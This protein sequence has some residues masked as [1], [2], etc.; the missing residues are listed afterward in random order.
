VADQFSELLFCPTLEALRNLEREGMGDRAVLSG[1]IMF[2]AALH[3]KQGA[4]ARGGQLAECFP[5]QSFALA[6]IH[7]AENTDDPHRLRAIFSVLE[8]IATNT[9]PVALP[10][11]PRT[12]K[13]IDAAGIE[14][15]AVTFLPPSPI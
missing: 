15:R 5:P 1:D 12:R 7:R 14:P 2:D 8:S 3:Y 11:H 10:L 4:E 6:T 13:R 9:C